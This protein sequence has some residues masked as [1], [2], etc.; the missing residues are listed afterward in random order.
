[1]HAAHKLPS[2]WIPQIGAESEFASSTHKSDEILR[3]RG[4]GRILPFKSIS[5][6][7]KDR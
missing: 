4:S 3:K 5:P 2:H 6:Q 1:M 7:N